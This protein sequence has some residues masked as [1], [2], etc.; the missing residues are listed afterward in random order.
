MQITLQNNSIDLYTGTS[1]AVNTTSWNNTGAQVNKLANVT[2]ATS[3]VATTIDS[4]DK[5]VYRSAKYIVQASIAGSYHAQE[6]LVVHDGATAT[7]VLG[8]AAV[9]SGSLGTITTSISGSNVLLQFDAA[10]NNT[11]VRIKKDY[12]LI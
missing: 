8:T 9:T 1:S 12:I 4:F 10:N 11:T 2:I 7:M 6:A 5:T 3:G